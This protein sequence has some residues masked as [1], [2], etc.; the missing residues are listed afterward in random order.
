MHHH[1]HHHRPGGRRRSWRRT[2]TLAALAPMLLL[3]GC[4]QILLPD[5]TPLPPNPTTRPGNV[6]MNVG[7]VAD[8]STELPFVDVVKM[9]RP[10]VSNRTGQPWGQGGPLALDADGWIQR[11]DA[12]QYGTMLMLGVQGHYPAGRYTLLYDG[13]GTL[14]LDSPHARIISQQPGRWE[15]DMTP[16]ATGGVQLQELATDP[17]NP[18]RNIRFVMPGY[19]ATY[20]TQPFNPRFLQRLQP[21]DT[22]RFNWWMRVGGGSNGPGATAH[23]ADRTTPTDAFQTDRGVALE[24]QI[25]LANQLDADP[26][27]NLPHDADDAYVRAFAAQVRDH[28][29]AGRTAYVEYSNETWNGGAPQAAYVM[30]KGTELGL[31]TDAYQA[32]L[33]YT[34]R[35]SAEIFAIWDDVFGGHTRFR[36]VIAGQAGNVWTGQQ[37]LGAVPEG[38]FD[39]LAM[40]PYVQCVR[41]LLVQ[42]DGL[43]QVLALTDD[44]LLDRCETEVREQTPTVIRSWKTLATQHGLE[45]AAYEGGQHLVGVNAA[46]QASAELTAKIGRVNRSVRMGDIY[47]LYLQQWKQLGGGEFV[48]FNSVARYDGTF[49]A[50]GSLEYQDQDPATAPKYRALVDAAG[51]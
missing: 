33:R 3:M 15:V 30:Q 23:W 43:A 16:S 10:W 36:R 2:A 21:F 18:I 5:G 13:S 27:F 44:Q 39:V 31:A 17:A 42:P 6:G 46:Q 20:A 49:G 14:R 11:L 28:L 29:E 7:W 12:G 50:F 48:A 1:P 9:A 38:S 32:G 22:L 51:A 8:F 35:R 34:A 45:L 4:Q 41:Q 24:Y 47:R 26:W 40:A 19:E 37:E 25:M